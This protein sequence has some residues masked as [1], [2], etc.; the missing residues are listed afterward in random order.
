MK[1]LVK[2][3]T[4]GRPNK[5]QQVLKQYIETSV[6]EDTKFLI[7][8]D[9][10]DQTMTSKVEAYGMFNGVMY[11]NTYFIAGESKSKIHA[12]NRDIENVKGWD[13]LVLVYWP[14]P[15]VCDTRT[16]GSPGALPRQYQARTVA[17]RDEGGLY[18]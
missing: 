6:L 5:F 3:P 4:R 9:V 8:Y 13:I 16:Q 12:C 15:A 1:I 18:W 7:S 10:D 11:P 14:A 17:D 2:F